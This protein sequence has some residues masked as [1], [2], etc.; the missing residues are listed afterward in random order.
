MNAHCHEPAELAILAG[1]P[2]GDPRRWH[3]RECPRCQALSMSY[4]EFLHDRSLPEGA[5]LTEAEARLGRALAGEQALRKTM[6]VGD[7]RGFPGLTLPQ[8]GRSVRWLL[9]SWRRPAFAVAVVVMLA[10]TAY[11]GREWKLR[12]HGPDV[13]RGGSPSPPVGS[14]GSSQQTNWLLPV[15]R[16]PAG[17]P[18]LRWRRQPGA[19]GYQVRLF[20][21]DLS[22]FARIGPQAD[23]VLVLGP[24]VLPPGTPTTGEIGWQVIAQLR[25]RSFATSPPAAL[26]LR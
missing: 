3:L 2:E 6:G 9:P 12:D 7:R 18:V 8:L 14:P 21:A 24:G 17:H 26:R 20:G 4:A 25:G 23:T 16:D 22:D 10:G 5:D 13:L 1:L 15:E 11:L 19:E